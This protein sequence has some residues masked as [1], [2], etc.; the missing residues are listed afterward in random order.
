MAKKRVEDI[1]EEA[2]VPVAEGM[3]LTIIDV[4]YK[5]EGPSYVL[6][7]IIDKPEGITIDDC[8]NLSRALGEKLDEI[9]PIED[10]YSLEVQSPGERKLNRDSE[11]EY[12]KGRDV[13]VKLF[14]GL[15][16][17]KTFEGKLVGLKDNNV[18]ITQNDGTVIEFDRKKVASV[19]LS[20]TF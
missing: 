16:G 6:R 3:G 18:S 9:D 13:E 1:V 20:I 15:K 7:V 12:F 5:K 19:K 2:A 10:S 4:E 17:K 8:E 11:F 14:K